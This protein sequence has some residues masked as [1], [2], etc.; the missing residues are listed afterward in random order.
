M[1]RV[2]GIGGVFFKSRDPKALAAWYEH[3]LGFRV[4]AKFP[5]AAIPDSA[6]TVW[7][8]HSA[9]TEYFAP[10]EQ[11]FMINPMVDDAAAAVAR[12]VERGATQVGELEAHDYGTVAWILDPE[13]NKPEFWQ[14]PG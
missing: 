9:D 7:S 8:P 2:L 11:P 10:S 3:C 5:A 14:P 4:S 13:G 6:L 1:T 12:A